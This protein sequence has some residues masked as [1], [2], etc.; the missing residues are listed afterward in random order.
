MHLIEY[1]DMVASRRQT[2][3]GEHVRGVLGGECGA[4]CG[5]EYRGDHIIASLREGADIEINWTRQVDT[6][7]GL[8]AEQSA[9]PSHRIG[10]PVQAGKQVAHSMLIGGIV[11]RGVEYGRR[12]H[13]GRALTDQVA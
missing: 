6:L 13:F 1:D 2:R 5:G 9:E 3:V 10:E 4:P 11:L 12:A 7:R 8:L